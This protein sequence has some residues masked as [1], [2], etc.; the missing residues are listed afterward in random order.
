MGGTV[1]A[2]LPLRSSSE[3]GHGGVEEADPS[4]PNDMCDEGAPQ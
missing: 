3:A 2:V 4:K 1:G